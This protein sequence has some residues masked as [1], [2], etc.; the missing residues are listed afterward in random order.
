MEVGVRDNTLPR[1]VRSVPRFLEFETH[2]V[3][4][5][6]YLTTSKIVRTGIIAYS[7]TRSTYA[8]QRGKSS[9]LHRRTHQAANNGVRVCQDRRYQLL[10]RMQTQ[11]DTVRTL[12]TR[13]ALHQMH[14]EEDASGPNVSIRQMVHRDHDDVRKDDVARHPKGEPRV[15]RWD[16]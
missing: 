10:V 1:E 3:Q 14:V 9:R 8:K 15:G 5:I 11:C 7:G 13:F 6:Q 16:E 4:Q 2:N 12:E